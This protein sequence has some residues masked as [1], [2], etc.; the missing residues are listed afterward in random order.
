MIK[1]VF[2]NKSTF[3][4]IEFQPGFN[5]IWADRTKEST[6]KDSRNGLGKSTLIEIIHFCLGANTVRGKGLLL[7]HLKG[8]SFS[9]VMQIGNSDITITRSIDHPSVV[10]IEGDT[11]TWTLK[12][13]LK[14]EHK[15]FSLKDWNSLL[16][17]LAFGLALADDE[18]KYQPSFRS[19][20]SYFIRRG[21]DAFSIPFEHHRKQ[22]EW[23]KQVNNAFL[24][25]LAWEDAADIQML[26]DRKKALQEFRKAAKTGVVKGFVGSLGELEAKKVRLKTQSEQE[27]SQIQSFRVHPQYSQVQI[28]ADALTQEIHNLVNANTM[29]KIKLALYNKSIEEERPPE[30]ES[31]EKIYKE[32]GVSLPGLS[33]RR[34]EEVLEFHESILTNRRSFLAMELDRLKREIVGREKQI[35]EISDKRASLMKI[36]HTHRALEEYTLIQK[37]HMDSVNSINSITNMIENLK[38]FEGGLSNINIAQEELQQKARRDYDERAIIRERAIEYFNIYSEKLYNAPGKLVIDITP[39]GFRYDVQIERSGSSGISNMK[40]FC[41]DMM[42][43][44]LWANRMPA[45]GFLIHDSTIFDGVDERQ[46]AL[47]LEIAA[48]DSREYGYQYICTLN[49]DYVPWAEFSADFDLKKHII[50]TLTDRNTDGC[51]LGIRF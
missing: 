37:R 32:A 43:S 11:S 21:K 5:V 7:E 17:N 38:E 19:L 12:E 45:P 44:K 6:K 16:G 46:R 26:K 35:Q 51:L 24:L 41:Y 29:Y 49:S 3:K 34:L 40:V 39:T 50:A 10:Q 20:I 27:E 18:R 14:K 22:V 42:L 4:T 47:A 28:D 33:L 15:T 30:S 31:I 13:S 36:L 25:G 48:I 23:D 9:M 1:R 8:W 2:A